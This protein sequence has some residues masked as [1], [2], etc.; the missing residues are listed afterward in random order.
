MAG[1]T[2]IEAP[3]MGQVIIPG[4]RAQ[5]MRAQEPLLERALHNE[6]SSAVSDNGSVDQNRLQATLAALTA[7]GVQGYELDAV[8]R[9]LAQ[10]RGMSVSIP[11]ENPS[12]L[13]ACVQGFNGRVCPP[14]IMRARARGFVAAYESLVSQLT[15]KADF[16][17]K[18]WH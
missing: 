11:S 14:D 15:D 8:K 18:L 13:K 5:P 12:G 10:A 4:W 16:W 9:L 3:K 6:V 7:D 17:T 1:I 2:G